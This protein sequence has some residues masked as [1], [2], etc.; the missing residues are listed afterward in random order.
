TIWGQAFGSWGHT[1]GD[2]NAASLT[3]STTGFFLGAD[4]PVA[5]NLRL[6]VL[7]GYSSSS[8]GINRRLSSA[9]SDDY[10]VG[11]YGGTQ[12][13]ALGFRAGASYTWHDL[14]TSRSVAF[15]GFADSLTASYDAGTTQV[16][17]D[18]GYR[19]DMG[20]AFGGTAFGRAAFEPFAN[21]AYVHL[22]TD[23]FAETGGAAALTG[24]RKDTSTTFTT[25]GVRASTAFDLGSVTLTA[26]GSLGWRHAFGDDTPLASL[27]FSGGSPFSIAGVPIA[28]DAAVLDLGLDFGIME[29]ATLGLSYGGQ[30]ATDAI[31][32]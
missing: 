6:G 2:G 30:F 12:W 29:N 19:I 11:I 7:G 27:S 24:G 28:K 9:G 31:D 10:H 13:G 26:R 3:R 23:G 1:E 4:A 22:H 14:K 25:L 17:G 16:F 18:L 32:Q 5:S 20:E 15:P 21:L 8:F